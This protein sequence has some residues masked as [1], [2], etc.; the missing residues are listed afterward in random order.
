M[1]QI[2]LNKINPLLKAN[3]NVKLNC[4][5]I[6]H[7]NQNITFKIDKDDIDIFL[8]GKLFYPKV[9]GNTM[10]I[11]CDNY[12]GKKLN[13][14]QIIMGEKVNEYERIY[15]SKP[16]V[17]FKNQ[18]K[19]DYRK[20]NLDVVSKRVASLNFSS[21]YIGISK[22]NENLYRI[23]VFNPRIGKYLVER[24]RTE[25][26]AA[27]AYDYYINLFYPS[28]TYYTNYGLG[29][30]PNEVL[31]YYN[32]NSISDIIHPNYLP[33]KYST[34]F[35]NSTGYYGVYI[36]ENN[37]VIARY[38]DPISG[39]RLSI[40][41]PLPKSKVLEMVARREEFLLTHPE[42]KAKSNV[43]YPEAKDGK[44]IIAG[45]IV[46]QNENI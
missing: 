40:G 35:N 8:S 32:I 6:T 46:K 17:F 27:M 11:T 30:Y 12:F 45:I 41:N 5:E 33:A 23:K 38:I 13:L 28:E 10:Y 31:S 34:A 16:I 29:K 24:F 43:K 19:L 26:E 3:F 25:I 39:R 44:I 37:T 20:S 9:V 15:R 36:T 4:W 7:I 18:D 1:E 22:E 21:N 14:Q 2:D 42:V